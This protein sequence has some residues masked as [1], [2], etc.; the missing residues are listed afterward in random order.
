MNTA[1]AAC[2]LVLAVVAGVGCVGTLTRAVRR[3]AKAAKASPST[4]AQAEEPPVGAAEELLPVVV[5]DGHTDVKMSVT[6]QDWN[7][8]SRAAAAGGDVKVQLLVNP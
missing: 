5:F 6:T 2:L 7:A 8:V 3:E 1:L 4:T